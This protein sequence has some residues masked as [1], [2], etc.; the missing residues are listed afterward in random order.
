MKRLWLGV[1]VLA[2]L[3]AAGFWAMDYAD[4]HQERICS[5]LEQATQAALGSDWAQVERLTKEVCRLWEDSWDAWATLSDHTELD[6]IDAGFARLEVYCH[7]GHTTDYAAECA[8][9]AR[10][11]EALGDGH[12]LSFRNLF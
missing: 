12:R 11:V 1:G 4:R 10:L 3:L 8:A 5:R 6:E 7:D 2:L 9:L